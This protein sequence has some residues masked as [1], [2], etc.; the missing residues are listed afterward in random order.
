MM[1]LMKTGVFV[2]VLVLLG[3]TGAIAADQP[4]VSPSLPCPTYSTA[5]PIGPSC[6]GYPF[7]RLGYTPYPIP[8][9]ALHPPVYYSYPVPRTYG[10]SPFAYP[11]G[12]MTPEVVA[13]EPLIIQNRFVPKA[14]KPVA[15]RDRVAQA[16]QR[17]VNPFVESSQTIDAQT[18]A[19]TRNP[20]PQIV[21]PMTTD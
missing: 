13:P 8:Y 3:T 18:V 6:Y 4:S 9:F 5:Y 20:S 21:F 1:A 7:G 12:T 11:P 16:P 10:Y 19:T 15:K 2:G 14:E 17:V